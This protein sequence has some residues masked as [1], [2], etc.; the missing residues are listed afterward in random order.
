GVVRHQI[1][2]TDGTI[3]QGQQVEAAIDIDR[4]NAIRRNHTA[5]HV[6]HWALRTVLGDHVKQQGSW[7]GPDRLRFDFSHYE[8]LTPEQIR[9]IEDLANREVLDNAPVRHYETTKEHAAEIGAIAF[10]G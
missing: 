2:L 7:V 4:R 3:E 5:T 10:F 6:L 1:E 9:A 8:A